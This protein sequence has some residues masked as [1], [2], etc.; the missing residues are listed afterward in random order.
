M[1]VTHSW[2]LNMVTEALTVQNDIC[3]LF[4]KDWMKS[5]LFAVNNLLEIKIKVLLDPLCHMAKNLFAC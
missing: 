2:V 3:N 1:I 5:S 4:I